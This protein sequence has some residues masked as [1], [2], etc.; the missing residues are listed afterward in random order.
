MKSYPQRMTT[1]EQCGVHGCSKKK[2]RVTCPPT[3]SRGTRDDHVKKN[4]SRQESFEGLHTKKKL[5]RPGKV[6]KSKR[7]KNLGG[8]TRVEK[9]C[10]RFGSGGGG[11]TRGG[12]NSSGVRKRF[13]G[14]YATDVR[15]RGGRWSSREGRDEL[16][17][18]P[19]KRMKKKK[20]KKI[21]KKTPSLRP[22]QRASCHK[23]NQRETRQE[24]RARGV[25]DWSNAVDKLKS[26]LGN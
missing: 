15:G 2:G 23:R 4:T 24:G 14:R 9:D 6:K 22:G 25:Q 10:R 12:K 21:G 26:G 5:K 8:K 1:G 20:K 18:G 7:K 13:A 17:R 11:K 3:S 19:E 16:T